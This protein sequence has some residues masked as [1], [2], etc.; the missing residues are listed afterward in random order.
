[1]A[2]KFETLTKKMAP[3]QV[4]RAKAK[5]KE[6]GLVRGSVNVNRLT[7]IRL[8]RRA[9]PDRVARSF[10]LPGNRAFPKILLTW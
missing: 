7:R 5:A 6:G 1:M 4:K 2:H 3:E 10:L 9:T 8:T